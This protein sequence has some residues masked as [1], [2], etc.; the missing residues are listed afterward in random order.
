[1]LFFFY[2]H[3]V[4]DEWGRPFRGQCYFPTVGNANVVSTRVSAGVAGQRVSVINRLFV[5]N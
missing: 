1:M 5:F 2:I 3:T 4:D